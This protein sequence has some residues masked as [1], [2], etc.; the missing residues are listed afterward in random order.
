[1]V[2]AVAAVLLACAG[3]GVLGA[4]NHT[5]GAAANRLSNEV[6]SVSSAV[7]S[8]QLVVQQLVDH[9]SFAT[10]TDI[11][12]LE[13]LDTANTAAAGLTTY[14]PRNAQDLRWRSDALTA[15]GHAVP[16]ISQARSW[17]NHG[18]PGVAT[19]QHELKT[20]SDELDAVTTTLKK[21]SGS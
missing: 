4:A 12:L 17:V 3:C 15:T 21:A 16:A 18:G 11:T 8:A 14:L 2:A 6:S 9:R 5:T 1:M 20:A 7:G 19:V 10:V 13:A